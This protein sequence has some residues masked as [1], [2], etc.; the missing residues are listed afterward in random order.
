MTYVVPQRF[1]EMLARG[2]GLG[3]NRILAGMH[4]PLDVIGGGIQ[5]Q[6]VAAAAIATRSDSNIRAAAFTQAQTTLMAAAGVPRQR[7]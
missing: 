3:E 4:S 5:G 7:T 2:L 6:V 1:Q